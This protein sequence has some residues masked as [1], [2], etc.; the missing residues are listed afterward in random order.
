MHRYAYILRECAEKAGVEPI[1]RVALQPGVTEVYRVTIHYPDL[2]AS[3]EVATY[4]RFGKLESMLE[5][6]YEG[7]FQRKP[8]VYHHSLEKYRAFARALRQIEFD[9]LPDAAGVFYGTELCMV[10]RAAGTFVKSVIFSPRHAEGSYTTLL[11]A[12]Q[13]FLPEVLREI[14]P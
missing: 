8:L 4:K 3:D 11:D 14:K 7:H 5:V 1:K 10:E 12:I 9:L 6:I 13:T 2:H